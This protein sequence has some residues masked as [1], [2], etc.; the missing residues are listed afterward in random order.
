MDHNSEI[1]SNYKSIFSEFKIGI[2]QYSLE[3]Q[4]FVW[5]ETCRHLYGL[6]EGQNGCHSQQWFS[7]FHEDDRSSLISY[8]EK[9]SH[10]EKAT[11][12]TIRM[13]LPNETFRTLKVKAY[14]TTTSE[15]TF[16]VGLNCEAGSE[17]PMTPNKMTINLAHEIN[18][19]LLII[20]GRAILLK[21]RVQQNDIDIECCKRDLD[22][23][24]INCERIDKVIKS[25]NRE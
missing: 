6:P 17:T 20:Q 13:S 21:K 12:V 15:G 7:K 23:I 14:K 18:N 8:F 16:L 3:T 1:L 24:Q 5:D 4:E 22:S 2:W 11:E 10:D 9:L 19:P 25:L